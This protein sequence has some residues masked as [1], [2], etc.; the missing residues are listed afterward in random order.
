M[1]S[2]CYKELIADPSFL[3][4][5]SKDEWIFIHELPYLDALHF[6]IV[7][8]RLF[9]WITSPVL[10]DKARVDFI[11]NASRKAMSTEIVPLV[12][13]VMDGVGEG[14]LGMVTTFCHSDQVKV[15]PSDVLSTLVQWDY[16]KPGIIVVKIFT[17]SPFLPR[18]PFAP[19][20]WT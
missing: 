16:P 2:D 8:K 9:A 10:W 20:T 3:Q 4:S 13:L 1:I 14:R 11:T 7:S 15:E 19:L 5:F 18:G 12:I 6:C 17:N